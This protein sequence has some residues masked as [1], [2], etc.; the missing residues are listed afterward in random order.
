MPPIGHI[1]KDFLKQIFAEEKVL[2]KKQAITT[3]HVSRYDELS[4]KAL[5]PS[6][7]KD[8]KFM[9]YFPDNYGDAKTPSREYFMNV[10]NTIY[11]DYMNKI[12][13]HAD[14]QRYSA[15]GESQKTESI[16]ISLPGKT[17]SNLCLIFHVSTTLPAKL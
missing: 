6:L 10:L 2:L 11:P 12:M 5:W 14:K 8:R 17:D 15:T 1:N 16:Y 3:V 13:L 7:S 4:V 9:A